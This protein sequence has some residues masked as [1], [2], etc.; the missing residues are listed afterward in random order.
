MLASASSTSAQLA[1]SPTTPSSPPSPAGSSPPNLANVAPNNSAVNSTEVEHHLITGPVWP[2]LPVLPVLRPHIL[3]RSAHVA[4]LLSDGARMA[5][6]Y[7]DTRSPS[8]FNL[9]P[10]RLLS[11]LTGRPLRHHFD[12]DYCKPWLAITSYVD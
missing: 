3:V 9:W 8:G 12:I 10:L 11:R 4:Y 6:W 7:A 5:A 1:I 2:R